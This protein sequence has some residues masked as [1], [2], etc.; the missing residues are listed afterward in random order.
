MPDD[1]DRVR[2]RMISAGL[3]ALEVAARDLLGRATRDAPIDTGALRAS[4]R[5]EVTRTRNGG[6]AEVSF[7]RPYAAAQEVSYATMMRDGKVVEWQARHHPKGGRSRYLGS[8]LEAMAGRYRA[9]LAAAIAKALH[10]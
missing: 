3:D 10:E 9:V 6:E 2:D 8:N 1:L 7:N 5:V 4:G